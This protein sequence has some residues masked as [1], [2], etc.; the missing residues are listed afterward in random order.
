MNLGKRGERKDLEEVK[1]RVIV[2]TMFCMGKESILN[3][4][5]NSLFLDLTCSICAL[6]GFKI[7]FLRAVTVS[8]LLLIVLNRKFPHLLLY[9]L[10]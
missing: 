5:K 9:L 6:L 3:S 8:K 1:R 10:Y 4:N 7:L 2:V